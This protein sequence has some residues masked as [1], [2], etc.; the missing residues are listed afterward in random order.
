M[1]ENLVMRR[2]L[3]YVAAALLAAA[4]P[5]FAQGEQAG[6]IRGR[7]ASSDGLPLPGATV[8]VASPALHRESTRFDSS[9]RALRPRH[10]G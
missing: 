2:L 1:K 9:C 10:A 7:L 5:V 6:A 8:S 4:A 3:L